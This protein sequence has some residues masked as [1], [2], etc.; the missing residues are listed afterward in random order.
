[1]KCPIWT[2]RIKLCFLLIVAICFFIGCSTSTQTKPLQITK[3]NATHYP[4]HVSV[5]FSVEDDYKEIVNLDSHISHLRVLNDTKEV[6]NPTLYPQRNQ[7]LPNYTILLIDTSFSMHTNDLLSSVK[8][9][10]KSFI[11]SMTINDKVMVVSYNTDIYVHSVNS[12]GQPSFLQNK[13]ELSSLIDQIQYETKNT[14]FYDAIYKTLDLFPPHNQQEPCNIVLFTDLAKTHAS[15]YNQF[16]ADHCKNKAAAKN[17]RLYTIVYGEDIEESFQKNI[18]KISNESYSS[19]EFLQIQSFFSEISAKVYQGELLYGISTAWF[20]HPH[21][22]PQ[23]LHHATSLLLEYAKYSISKD[24]NGLYQYPNISLLPDP[25]LSTND[26]F[27]FTET[28][29]HLDEHFPKPVGSVD[30]SFDE[31]LRHFIQEEE[32]D[33]NAVFFIDTSCSHI[34]SQIEK[35]LQFALY[36]GISLSFIIVGDTLPWKA[37]Y[38]SLANKTGGFVLQMPSEIPIDESIYLLVNELQEGY[39]FEFSVPS[40]SKLFNHHVCSIQNADIPSLSDTKYYFSGIINTAFQYSP[41]FR[42]FIFFLLLLLFLLLIVFLLLHHSISKKRKQKNSVSSPE[43]EDLQQNTQYD[44]EYTV[45]NNSTKVI[46][47]RIPSSV[48][49][50][51]VVHGGQRGQSFSIHEHPAKIGRQST[52]DILL[53]DASVSRHH[54]TIFTKMENRKTNYYIQDILSSSGTRVNN[55]Q[56]E[57]PTVLH[58]NDI[59]QCGDST[60]MYKTIENSRFLDE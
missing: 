1:M 53:L 6:V 5:F 19:L 59:I 43:K 38:Q 60:L 34:H 22:E 12:E 18:E 9:N 50:L 17:V 42:T 28:L 14:A 48:S 24:S 54:A 33:R 36:N 32:H 11:Q 7:K 15:V 56:I 29:M 39:R 35:S 57:K 41:Y 10:L 31:C 16:T 37:K 4:K 44:K 26:I 27:L 52:C 8:E 2:K 40:S 46:A 21:L 3:I 49:W 47:K 23:N 30:H 13:L 45:P 25:L 20:L 58:D 51:C 55:D